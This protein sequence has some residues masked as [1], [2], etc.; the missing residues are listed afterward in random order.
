MKQSN[1]L[2]NIKDPTAKHGNL[3]D[4]FGYLLLEHYCAQY[5][6][7]I[8]RIG[9]HEKIPEDTYAFVGSIIHLCHKKIKEQGDL[10]EL[11]KS[12]KR[13]FSE[14]ETKKF[15]TLNDEIK[16]LEGQISQ[17]EAEE[18]AKAILERIPDAREFWYASC[19]ASQRAATLVREMVELDIRYIDGCNLATDI[20]ILLKT[21]GVLVQRDNA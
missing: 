19:E 16:T 20:K 14:D 9:V 7:N 15:N 13:S 11:R 1:I 17:R 6:V 3:G 4:M 12:E 10:L 2:A 8:N 18:A 5:S 21:A